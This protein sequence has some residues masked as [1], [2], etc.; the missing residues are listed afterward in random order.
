LEKITKFPQ[1]KT[2]CSSIHLFIFKFIFGVCVYIFD[3]LTSIPQNIF[4]ECLAIY[5]FISILL[6]SHIGDH[7]QEELAKFSYKSLTIVKQLRILPYS[8]DLLKPGFFF[9]EIM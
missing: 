4:K 1:K 9:A 7:P 8:G 3:P 5:L 2:P 6:G